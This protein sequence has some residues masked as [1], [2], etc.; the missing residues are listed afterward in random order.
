MATLAWLL[1]E[2]M[3]HLIPDAPSRLSRVELVDA[4]LQV[5]AG[6]AG[7]LLVAVW[8][9]RRSERSAAALR[10]QRSRLL[11]L[12]EGL[13]HGLLELDAQ[14]LI[15]F[16]NPAYRLILG[17]QSSDLSRLPLWA[18]AASQA[19][20]EALRR[21]FERFRAVCPLRGTFDTY[22]A[23]LRRMDGGVRDVR[24]DWGRTDEEGTSSTITAVVTDVTNY[25]QASRRL[26][27]IQQR[28]QALFDHNPDPVYL[29]DAHG[30][31]LDRN[32]AAV[33]LTGLTRDEALGQSIDRLV[34]EEDLPA[35]QAGLARALKG[36][37][38]W[39][40][41]RVR[42]KAGET[43]HLDV[44]AVPLMV[45]GDVSGAFVIA[46]QITERVEAERRLRES[47]QRY[48]AL[49][50]P[51]PD[52]VYTLDPNGYFTSAN[53]ATARITGHS[54]QELLGQSFASL[55]AAEDLPRTYEHFYRALGGEPQYFSIKLA[56]KDGAEM[57][58]DVTAA[59]Y[60]VDGQ[61]LGVAGIS[62]D[63]TARVAAEEHLSASREE[64][65]RLSGFL[66][67]AQENERRRIARELHDELGQ[68]LSALKMNVAWLRRHIPQDSSPS[69]IGQ[70]D[71]M[72]STIDATVE[73]VRR[74]AANLRPVLLDEL[75]LTAACEWLIE[76][77]G[78]RTGIACSLQI[79]PDDLQAEEEVSTACFRILQEA[80]TNVTRH[81]QAAHVSVHLELEGHCL[82]LVVKDDGIGLP[83]GERDPRSFGLIGMRERTH[84][85]GGSFQI[86]SC[87]G[88]GT[89]IHARL[90]LQPE[91][92][93]ELE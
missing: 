71:R 80:L 20:S 69:A 62:K 81:A 37:P 12:V 50:E 31:Y 67:T 41:V 5:I 86:D 49:F 90:P 46:K 45:D 18:H 47:E 84:A 53:P 58:V 74:L 88:E 39:M 1:A 13:P 70:L 40:Q 6:A 19:E 15:V 93:K 32:D 11:A 65:R 3:G 33:A 60:V 91:T 17:A 92:P 36:E 16:A 57:Y 51:N 77:F 14:G 2:G 9:R 29:F 79:R 82:R 10:K 43:R 44:T 63:V 54:I 27:D 25:K 28:Y 23:Q 35:A 85:L 76:D 8:Y 56:R 68:Y 75:G 55:I 22:T 34:A 59:P 72:D 73:S 83:K 61:V 66:Q 42:T 78:R 38:E 48:R 64:L 52:A 26:Q 87:P 7:I 30:H 89:S 24:F 4:L 21:E